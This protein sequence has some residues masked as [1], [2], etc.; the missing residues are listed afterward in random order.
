AKGNR[1]FLAA[2]DHGT[3][4]VFDLKSGA[5]LKTVTGF[6]TPHS[7]FYVPSNTTSSVRSGAVKLARDAPVSEFSTTSLPG[8]RVTT[9]KR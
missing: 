7:I 9:N 8:L 4:E 3:L 1:L 2:E 5:H 6:E